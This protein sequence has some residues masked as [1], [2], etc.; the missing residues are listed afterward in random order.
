MN[1]DLLG[2]KANVVGP[3]TVGQQTHIGAPGH[4]RAV[5]LDDGLCVL[6]SFAEGR[7]DTYHVQSVQ[8][9]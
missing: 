9:T 2:A 3:N 6:L 8:L 5:Y 1:T 4:I 7:M